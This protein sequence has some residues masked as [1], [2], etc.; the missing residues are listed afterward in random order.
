MKLISIILTI[1]IVWSLNISGYIKN[2]STGEPIYNANIIIKDLNIGTSSNSKGY[3]QLTTYSNNVV[4]EVSVIG[5]DKNIQTISTFD[6]NIQLEI[7]LKPKIIQHSEI[8]VQ[9]TLKYRSDNL[10]IDI[11]NKK[12]LV[13]LNNKSVPEVL[14]NSPG[15]DIQYAYANGRNVNMSIRGSSDYKPGGYNNRILLLL[16]GCPISIPNSGS[17][18]WN[19]LPLENI[20]S[21]E[22]NNN[23]ASS[24]YGHN[25]M[26]GIINFITNSKNEN[27]ISGLVSTGSF[28][29]KKM[30]LEYKR[31]KKK[32]FYTINIT[33]QISNGHRYNAD[34][35]INRIQTNVN[36]NPNN[37][38][39]Y[40][41]NYFVSNS[42]VGHP[43]FDIEGSNKYRRSNRLTQYTQIQSFHK[44]NKSI[45][46]SQSIFFNQ[47]NTKYFN[48][49]DIPAIWLEENI[50]SKKTKYN[51]NNI[52]LR[53]EILFKNIK[54]CTI[55]LGQDFDWSKSKVDLLNQQYN[56]PIQITLGLFLQSKYI[57][58]ENIF[59]KAGI[60]YDYRKTIPGNNFLNRIYNQIT[61]KLSFNYLINENKSYYISISQGFRAPS[62]SELYLS[63][64]TTYGLEVKGNPELLP[65]KVNSFEIV[66]KNSE[67]N[68][69]IWESSIF[70]NKYENMIDFI[71]DVPTIAKN[72]KGINSS[73][74][75]YKFNYSPFKNISIN[76][77]YSYLNMHDLEK[78]P[79]LYRPKHKSN[80]F[81]N[82]FLKKIEI[83]LGIKIKSKQLYENFLSDFDHEK[84]FPLETLPETIISEIIF[85][86]KF[87]YFKAI[88][89]ISNLT[90]TKY[91]FIQNYT[92][93]KRNW[94]LTIIKI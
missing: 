6:K 87:N 63:H 3:F 19:S 38:S 24:Q 31:G 20:E 5:F 74:F 75:E 81:L 30:H 55:M 84:G 78:K 70:L 18:D 53:S 35:N 88:V 27:K 17:I 12:K 77:N 48:R 33:N 68:Y 62:I 36:F 46:I 94:L 57:I 21:I 1:N 82:L 64:I 10:S 72:R 37:Q 58:N 61:P 49:N 25:S 56:D 28:N 73:G 44:L 91:E 52:G 40:K 14:Q 54:K 4:L 83:K 23:S 34:N 16:N 15:V 43:G 93:P 2:F 85:S 42:K 29:S 69:W 80:L 66:H 22:I 41:L 8:E 65:E 11:L 60:R 92:M 71:Y 9:S 89:K 39:V 67:N 13:D 90:N 59:I 7:L 51:D 86:K 79:I 76:G 50:L 47:F 32:W 45:S 26:G